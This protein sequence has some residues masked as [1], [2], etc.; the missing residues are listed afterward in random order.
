MPPGGET[1]KNVSHG[2][3]LSTIS[4]TNGTIKPFL[5]FS[6]LL[7]F[8]IYYHSAHKATNF[9]LKVYEG[10]FQSTWYDAGLNIKSLAW[11]ALLSSCQ[12]ESP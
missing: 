3:N 5:S 4:F 11:G 12:T 6:C 2:T 7:S 1:A 10:A 8:S 9:S